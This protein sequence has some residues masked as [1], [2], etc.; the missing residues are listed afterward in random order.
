MIRI[1]RMM[2][3]KV[4]LSYCRVYLQAGRVVAGGCI[5][6]ASF[7]ICVNTGRVSRT[8]L[9]IYSNQQSVITKFIPVGESS[10]QLKIVYEYV[11][12]KEILIHDLLNT[13]LNIIFYYLFINY[14]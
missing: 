1:C 14:S 12:E 2:L 7:E 11:V 6:I 9:I 4:I 8:R 10:P 13:K 5:E 3:H